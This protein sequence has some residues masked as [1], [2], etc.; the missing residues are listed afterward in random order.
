MPLTSAEP[1]DFFRSEPVRVC[2]LIHIYPSYKNFMRIGFSSSSVCS[3]RL[4]IHVP[5][6][7]VG[8]VPRLRNSGV[9]TACS[10]GALLDLVSPISDYEA[11][12]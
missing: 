2:A 4:D 6:R 12:I 11:Q 10:D 8:R 5:K 3:I 9:L 1:R 7:G